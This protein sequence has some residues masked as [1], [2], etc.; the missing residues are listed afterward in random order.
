MD[1]FRSCLNILNL[2]LALG[3]F[4]VGC[5]AGGGPATAGEQ[6]GKAFSEL[7]V[8][9]GQ[10]TRG[11]LRPVE[12]E[13]GPP[14]AAPV[15]GVRIKI[16]GQG[17]QESRVAVTDQEGHYRLSLPVGTYRVEMGPLPPMQFTKDLPATVT[18][19]PGQET[20]KNILIDTGMR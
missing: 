4:W 12:R 7:G 19:T 11:P 3:L 17:A 14:N 15:P 8:L 20:R 13:G 10:V 1:I 18:I 6:K 9:V 16:M 5:S 2:T